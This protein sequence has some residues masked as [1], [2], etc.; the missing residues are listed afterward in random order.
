MSRSLSVTQQDALEDAPNSDHTD[1]RLQIATD[2]AFEVCRAST[3]K[4]Y[5]CTIEALG[6]EILIRIDRD[7]V[8][9]FL[10][11][12]AMIQ[13]E[14]DRVTQIGIILPRARKSSRSAVVFAATRNSDRL[15]LVLDNHTAH[16]LETSMRAMKRSSTEANG[17]NPMQIHTI[18]DC[19]SV[20]VQREETELPQLAEIRYV[21]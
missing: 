13:D 4:C 2:I 21:A 17:A 14:P 19:L 8:R 5:R 16:V 1:R 12:V 9:L 15:R 7:E 10:D 11:P 3:T 6:L 18:T 20:V